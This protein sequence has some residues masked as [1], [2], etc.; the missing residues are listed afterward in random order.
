MASAEF[1]LRPLHE[2]DGSALGALLSESPDTGRIRTAVRYWK[3][4]LEVWQATDQDFIG[5]VAEAPGHEGLVGACMARFG[6]C[7]FEGAVRP[8]ALLH[9]LM[10]HPQYRRRGI[11]S[12]LVGWLVERVRQRLG[13]EGV[14][15]ALVQQGNVGSMRTL[16]KHLG[17]FLEERLFAVSLKPSSKVPRPPLGVI[18]R[19]AE[20]SEFG[21][22]A[23][24]LNRFYKDY[25]FYEPLT[26][27]KLASWCANDLL[28]SPFRH[29]FVALD[30]EGRYLA[31]A[32]VVESYRLRVLEVRKLPRLLGL[33]NFFLRMVPADGVIRGLS[34]S[35][36]WVA[37]GQ[38]AAAKY[39]VDTI[40]WRWHGRADLLLGQFS[41]LHPFLPILGMRPWSGVTKLAVAVEGPVSAS[42]ERPV[43]G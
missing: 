38:L 34:L 17:Q 5:V 28:G 26:G 7:Q 23:D 13:E 40:R 36:V 10:V 6:Y 14:I 43:Y 24:R 15:W 39:L 31:G 33:V 27:E 9:T 18:V 22:I 29:Y 16:C 21:E 3:G 35:K 4:V 8:H 1:F 19:L 12:A 37:P 30:A 32:G 25:N 2:R 11:A 42:L 41:P 20:P